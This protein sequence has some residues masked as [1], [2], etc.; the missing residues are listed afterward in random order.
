MLGE[1]RY[2][3]EMIIEDINIKEKSDGY[4]LCISYEKGFTLI[5]SVPFFRNEEMP[6]CRLE[7]GHFKIVNM[8]DD[9][10][11][12]VIATLETEDLIVWDYLAQIK[13]FLYTHPKSRIR[14]LVHFGPK[15]DF[16]Q[17][18]TR[19]DL[20]QHKYSPNCLDPYE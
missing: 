15:K 18:M 17:Y 9:N 4:K 20:I 16:Y 2:Y 11:Q 19:K 14:M 8:L 1:P 13:D 6:S 10:T 12:S 5:F 3:E 7:D